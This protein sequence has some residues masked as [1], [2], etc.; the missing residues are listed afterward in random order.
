MQ[1]LLGQVRTRVVSEDPVDTV[2][3]VWLKEHACSFSHLSSGWRVKATEKDVDL[4][5]RVLGTLGE[6]VSKQN[7]VSMRTLGST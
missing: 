6:P 5:C 1:S 2:I 7:E 3:T 4:A